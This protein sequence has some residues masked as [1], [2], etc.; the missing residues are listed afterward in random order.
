MKCL[1]PT[2][3]FVVGTALMSYYDLQF[4]ALG[5]LFGGMSCVLQSVSFELGKRLVNH[6]KDLWSVL[7]INALA[8]TVIQV[9]FMA[10]TGEAQ[11]LF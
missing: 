11:S 7:L 1:W 3:L 2:I 10:A 5:Y 4:S 8:S 9:L 6:G